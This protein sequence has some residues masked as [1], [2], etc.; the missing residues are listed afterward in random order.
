MMRVVVWLLK[1]GGLV[2]LG[3]GALLYFGQR[4]L[5]Y[6]PVAEN[7]AE[8]LGV[9]WLQVDGASVKL[10]V[11]NP[12]ASRALLYFGGNAEDV[13]FNARDFAERLP[14]HTVYLVNY[15]GYGGSS[16]SPTEGALFADTLTVFDAVRPRHQ[17]VDVMGRS[18]GSGIAV[19]LA[20]E[21]DIGR[22]VLATPHD[23]AAAIAR[24]LYP[25]YPIDWLLKDRYDSVRYASAVTG[26][27]MLLIAEHD[28]IIPAAHSTRLA[29]AFRPVQVDAVV[30]SG[31]DHN[32]IAGFE[33]YWSAL[34]DFLG[35]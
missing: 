17:G 25:V 14:G 1:I 9:E 22:L 11:V 7:P 3:F 19:Y 34:A 16:G 31:A 28:R 8:D 15:R 2:Y 21:R 12:G 13:Y 27:V 32:S 29:E 10:W 4:N 5:M 35:H 24:R 33:R 26:P 23:S 30:V 6:L 20:S 18:L